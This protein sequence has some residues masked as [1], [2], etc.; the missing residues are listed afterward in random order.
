M[1]P[2]ARGK[3]ETVGQTQVSASEHHHLLTTAMNFSNLIFT[4]IASN[5]DVTIMTEFLAFFAIAGLLISKLSN[6]LFFG[7]SN[8]DSVPLFKTVEQSIFAFLVFL[9]ALTLGD[10]RANFSKAQDSVINESLELRQYVFLLDLQPNP[11][12]AQQKKQL[13]R[14]VKAVVSD[15]WRSLAQAEPALSAETDKAFADLRNSVK[16]TV[17]ESGISPYMDKILAS[18]TKLENS[19]LLRYQLAT[20]SSPRVFWLYIAILMLLG[21]V[22]TGHAK[23]DLRRASVLGAYY[24]ALG[25]VVGLIM[26]MDQPFRGE[27]SIS[28]DPFRM[29]LEQM[30]AAR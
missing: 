6:R 15:E 19:R 5:S 8:M 27:T 20:A 18:L 24:G 16:K 29:V 17:Q 10:V 28:S 2:P 13:E 7:G 26:I 23:L 14:Y 22:M 9:L 30:A 25:M 11:F 4:Y 3:S 21:S 12:T 1:E